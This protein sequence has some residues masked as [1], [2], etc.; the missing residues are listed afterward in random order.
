MLISEA[1]GFQEDLYGFIMCQQFYHK[2]FMKRFK[3]SSHKDFD[4]V[5]F[6]ISNANN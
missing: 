3:K 4:K 1:D 5:I 6:T 2:L